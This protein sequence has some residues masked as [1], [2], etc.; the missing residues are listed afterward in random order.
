MTQKKVFS[1]TFGTTV[2]AIYEE[3]NSQKLWLK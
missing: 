3:F 2:L 1:N